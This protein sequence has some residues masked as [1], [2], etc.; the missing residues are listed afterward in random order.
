MGLTLI[1]NPVKTLNMMNINLWKAER[2][3]Q[4]QPTVF[5][6]R[7]KGTGASR[8]YRLGPKTKIP[9]YMRTVGL[10][11]KTPQYVNKFFTSHVSIIHYFIFCFPVS[12]NYRSRNGMDLDLCT[13]GTTYTFAILH[14]CLD[15]VIWICLPLSISFLIFACYFDS[16]FCIFWTCIST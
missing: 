5:L 7:K 6:N 11:F 10:G 2:A 13:T 8:K 16:I 4:K 3:F 1:C 14:E 15:F 9:R 12:P